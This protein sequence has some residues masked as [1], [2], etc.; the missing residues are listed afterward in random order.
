MTKY[1]KYCKSLFQDSNFKFCP[2]CGV[3]LDKIYNSNDNSNLKRDNIIPK[4]STE[5][6]KFNSSTTILKNNPSENIET[7]LILAQNNLDMLEEM[8]DEVKYE[9]NQALD[10]NSILEYTFRVTKLKEE[11][12]KEKIKINK[13]THE[14]EVI[15]EQRNK[16]DTLFKKLYISI[17]PKQLNYFKNELQVDITSKDDFIKYVLDNFSD[18]EINELLNSFHSLKSDDFDNYVKYENVLFNIKLLLRRYNYKHWIDKYSEKEIYSFIRGNDFKILEDISNE[19]EKKDNQD[20]IIILN[21]GSILTSWD[22]IE[23]SNQEKIIYLIEDLTNEYDLESKYCEFTSLKYAILYG[24]TPKIEN[25]SEMFYNCKDLVKISFYECDSSGLKNM[26][27]MF[28]DC[29]S[30]KDISDLRKLNVSNVENMSYLFNECSFLEDISSLSNWDVS[31]VVDMAQMFEKC[32]LLKNLN[33]LSNWNVS[34]VKF[35]E[36]MFKECS[37]LIDISALSK[38]DVSN[39]T[40]IEGIFYNCENLINGSIILDDW[41]IPNSS[42]NGIFDEYDDSFEY[43]SNLNKDNDGTDIFG[44][45]E[46]YDMKNIDIQNQEFQNLIEDNI[47]TICRIYSIPNLGKKFV[48]KYITDNYDYQDVLIKLKKYK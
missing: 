33:A 18:D 34:N 1:C 28:G 46:S 9:L 8:L 13:L 26:Y 5:I 36:S 15:E 23:E 29:I 19:F 4:N 31:N 6:K 43:E 11:I 10:E 12:D 2:F 22:E 42:K 7:E 30:L 48:I 20:V 21:D 16:E 39:D 24:I 32:S 38:W 27:R 17:T 25:M 35:M 14:F 37:S 44:I 45:D 40:E 3:K 41:R 47:E